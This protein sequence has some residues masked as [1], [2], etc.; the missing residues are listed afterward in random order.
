MKTCQAD[1][2]VNP[3]FGGGFCRWHQ[4]KRVRKPKK[5]PVQ[6]TRTHVKEADFGFE[7]QVTLFNWLWDNA[8]DEKG[9]VTCPYTQEKLNRFYN[10]ELW[11]S[12]FA[13]VLPKGRY[14][15]WK[16][17]PKNLRVVLPDFHFC[18]DQQIRE[19]RKDHPTW[20]F[21]L[22]DKETEELKIEYLLFKKSNLLA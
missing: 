5:M 14:T 13:H 4:H 19:S 15:Y 7:D 9:V 12:C 11:Y 22:W 18:V 8:K 6:S 10:T 16:L 20:S 17:N 3:V 21:A 2:C 1:N